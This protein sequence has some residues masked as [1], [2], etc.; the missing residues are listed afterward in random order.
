MPRLFLLV[1]LIAGATGL[2]AAEAPGA[3]GHS[4]TYRGRVLTERFLHQQAISRRTAALTAQQIRQARDDQG[5]IAVIDTSNGVVP[6]PNFF[7]LEGMTLRFRATGDGYV[8]APEPLAFDV[9]AQANGLAIAL[10]DDD[11]MRVDLEFSFPFFGS[12]YSSIWVNSDGNI[13]FGE[14]DAAIASRSLAR[15][16]S[17]APRIAPLFVDLDPS[18]FAARVRVDARPDRVLVTW[19]GV[20]QFSAAGT[21]RRQVFQAE[22]GED[23]S[24]AFHYQTANLTAV[25]VGVFPGRLEAQPAPADFSSGPAG[26]AGGGLAELFQLAAALDIFAAG[27]QFYRNHGDA[28]D[29]IVLFNALGL[30]A[31]PGS[32]AFEVNVRNEILGIGDLLS[33]EPVFDFGPQ[34]GSRKRLASFLNMGPLASYPSDPSAR[35]PLIGENSTLSVLGQEAGHR[36]GVY[37][38]FLNPAT[39]LP[40]SNLLGRQDAHW[41]FFFNS[42]AS[43]LEGNAI[44]DHGEGASP[45]FE[46]VETVSRYGDFDQYIM[47]LRGPEEVA[48]SFL[49]LNPRNAGSTSR[50]RQPQTEVRFDGD[51]QD[52]DIDMVVAAEGTRIPD[53][54]VAERELRFAFVLLIDRNAE[55][56]AED[57]AKLDRIRSEW[58]SY[59][60][61]AVAN[62]ATAYTTLVRPLQLS[63]APA[64]GLLQG[65]SGPVRLDLDAPLEEDLLVSLGVEGEAVS[66]PSELTVPAGATSAAFAITGMSEGVAVLRADAAL[67][68][69]D[70]A[71]ARIQVTADPA[72]LSIEAESGAGQTGTAGETLPEPVVF[73]VRDRNRLRYLGARLTV[74]AL[75][76]GAALSPSPA[77]DADGLAPVGWRLGVGAAPKL[78][79]ARLS[80]R[81]EPSLEVSAFAAGA[82]PSFSAA[83]VVNAASFNQGPAADLNGISPGGLVSIFG[84]GFSS[85]TEAARLLPL[86]R[87]LAGSSVRVNGVPAPLL[88]VSPGQINLQLPFEVTGPEA[89][90]VVESQA[91]SSDRISVPVAPTQPGVFTDA[92][93]GFAAVIYAADAQAPWNRPANPGEVLQV[94]ATGLGAVS[95]RV[96]S[97]EA[98]PSLV[99]SPTLAAPEVLVGGRRLVPAFSGLAPF[100]AGLYQIN[101]QLPADL[102][103]GSHELFIEVDGGRSNAGLIEIAAP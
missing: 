73:S 103:S 59:F 14:G 101:V 45:R 92:A 80:G 47:G 27:Q 16:V 62:R 29:F 20:P 28:Y 21:G 39:G 91:G 34:F 38:E 70:Q 83:G 18:R 56:R 10:G 51:R 76:G 66:T 46:T 61:Q 19:D 36:W 24:I 50:A 85:E 9:P 100:F 99:L 97:G 102:P 41:S 42:Q 25:V 69:F 30:S 5:D 2:N 3:Y 17:G 44:T 77:T 71:V 84:V 15:A 74:N 43:V 63:A 55:P 1:F 64:A 54:T 79:R 94:F 89:R 31:G 75:G 60:N 8:S 40:S 4:G 90:I 58:E 82:R 95:P 86:P 52:I 37:L 93:T 48:P 11:S 57:V 87:A 98:A 23:G 13:T 7:D 32:F 26:P 65:D 96:E 78:L 68:G 12:R 22:L 33:P 88:L 67:P 53:H 81:T 35:I 49:V 6:A 72:N